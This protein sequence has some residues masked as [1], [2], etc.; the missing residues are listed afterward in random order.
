M[1]QGSRGK[2]A[3]SEMLKVATKCT[4]AD[5]TRPTTKRGMRVRL[6]N[7]DAEIDSSSILFLPHPDSKPA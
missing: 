4:I 7:L 2:Q 6:N 5:L 3:R 1:I